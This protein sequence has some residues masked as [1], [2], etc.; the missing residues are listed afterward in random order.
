MR[1]WLLLAIRHG[2]AAD[3]QST[4]RIAEM[5]ML[6]AGSAI[7]VGQESLQRQHRP[8]RRLTRLTL[9]PDPSCLSSL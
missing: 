7:A 5:R 6:A 8:R 4:L 3:D 1:E 9:Q 2:V